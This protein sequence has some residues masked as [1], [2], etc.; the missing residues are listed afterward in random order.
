MSLST[1]T[2]DSEAGQQMPLSF[3]VLEQ[4]STLFRRRASSKKGFLGKFRWLRN[5]S[6]SKSNISW[7]VKR[8]KL[9]EAIYKPRKNKHFK[10][11]DELELENGGKHPAKLSLFLHPYGYEED[12][13]RN[14]TLSVE[15]A[16]SVKSNIPSSARVHVEVT[17]SESTRGTRIAEAVLEN[18]ADCRILRHKGFLSHEQLKVL[19]C[20]HI[21]IAAT[22]TLFNLQ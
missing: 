1:L 5:R 20:E 15:M 13:G 22:A 21:E 10:C 2:A 18:S 12:A 4:S 3:D 6:D 19:E 17:A 7:S 11:P 8:D 14:L 16:A 9:N